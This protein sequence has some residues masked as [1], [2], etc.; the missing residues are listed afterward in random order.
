MTNV[1]KDGDR[2]ADSQSGYAQDGTVD[3][4]EPRDERAG[5]LPGDD[6]SSQGKVSVEPR[7]PDTTTVGLHTGLEIRGL[8]ALEDGANLVRCYLVGFCGVSVGCIECRVPH[9]WN[10]LR[11]S[12]RH[13]G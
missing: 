7:V 4:D 13:C 3:R 5:A 10:C 11:E 9:G 6:P 8:G 2:T 1:G 12:R